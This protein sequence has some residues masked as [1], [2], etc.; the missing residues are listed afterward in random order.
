MHL[1]NSEEITDQA[2][3]VVWI[4]NSQVSAFKGFFV[5]FVSMGVLASQLF[6][7]RLLLVQTLGFWTEI[8]SHTSFQVE[9]LESLLF[10]LNSTINVLRWYGMS[11]KNE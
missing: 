10:F 3:M 9:S 1:R 11:Y 4:L 8:D 6:T 5:V 7:F 2:G